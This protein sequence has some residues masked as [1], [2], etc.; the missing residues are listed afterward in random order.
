MAVGFGVSHPEHVR[1]LAPAVDGIIVGSAL[2]SA[3]D[4]GGPTAV[5]RLVGD[6]AGA[7]RLATAAG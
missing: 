7:T 2:V 3:L 1:E 6:L 5:G 4:G